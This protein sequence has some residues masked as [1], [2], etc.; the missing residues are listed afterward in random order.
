MPQ[1]T[2]KKTPG[3]NQEKQ[4]SMP[5]EGRDSYDSLMTKRLVTTASALVQNGVEYD[6]A[7]RCA[8]SARGFG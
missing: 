7:V 3:T 6:S 5:Q 8:C 2:T 1:E 4:C